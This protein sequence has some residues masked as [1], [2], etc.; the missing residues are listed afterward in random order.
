M[1]NTEITKGQWK[2]WEQHENG[3]YKKDFGNI[4]ILSKHGYF[5]VLKGH[6]FKGCF[7]TLK[8]ALNDKQKR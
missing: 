7:D 2:G 3:T 4:R 6:E 1:K 5:Y 8:E